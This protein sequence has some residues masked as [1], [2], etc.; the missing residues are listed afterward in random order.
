[1]KTFVKYY[2]NVFLF[3]YSII[4]NYLKSDKQ[5]QFPMCRVSWY[6]SFRFHHRIPRRKIIHAV[7]HSKLIDIH[8][9][10]KY[11]LIYNFYN[12]EHV[13]TF[14]A[15]IHNSL[16]KTSDRRSPFGGIQKN[17]SILERT[18]RNWFEAGRK[19]YFLWHFSL[20]D[21]SENWVYLKKEFLQSI[22]K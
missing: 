12:I 11:A 7:N 1:M 13:D 9:S 18:Q 4:C 17:V 21:S 2:S 5:H 6:I 15:V 8:M 22:G 19:L 20:I 14:I 16:W 10:R 3:T